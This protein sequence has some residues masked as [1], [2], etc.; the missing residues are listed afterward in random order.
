MAPTDIYQSVHPCS[1]LDA[2]PFCDHVQL[3][4]ADRAGGTKDSD[5]AHRHHCS[6]HKPAAKTGSAANT[7][8]SR[9]I[10]PPWPGKMLPESFTWACRLSRLSNRRS[11]E[12]T[13]ELQ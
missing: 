4:A 9:S 1:L 2:V 13:S 5:R 8:S 12:H 11:E 6:S 10:R 7:L 3:A